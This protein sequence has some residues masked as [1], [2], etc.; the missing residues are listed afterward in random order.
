M[1]TNHNGAMPPLHCTRRPISG[2]R[3]VD[4][5]DVALADESADLNCIRDLVAMTERSVQLVDD[6]VNTVE[7]SEERLAVAEAQAMR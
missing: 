1:S 2:A 4:A 3:A 5:I 6:G 7:V